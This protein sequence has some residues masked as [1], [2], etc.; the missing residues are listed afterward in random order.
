MSERRRV[1]LRRWRVPG[2]PWA[3]VLLLVL[4]L[5]VL[6]GGPLSERLQLADPDRTNVSDVRAVL[7]SLPQ[8]P[9]VIVGM[10]ADLGTYPEIRQAV[11]ALLAD[12]LAADGRI[13][14]V[15]FSPEG[16]AIADAEMGRLLSEGIAVDRLVDY[17]F[18]AGAEAGLV[19]AVTDLP[20]AE[21]SNALAADVRAL[22]GGIAA[23]DVAIVVGGV[24]FGPRSWVEQVATRLP[25]LPIVA[26]APTFAEP[27]L[28]PYLR[29]GQVKALLATVRDDA[30][31]VEDVSRR[32]G[33]GAEA[34]PAGPD[35][36]A[37]LIGMLVA[38]GAIAWSVT[39]GGAG[40][41]GVGRSLEEPS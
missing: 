27:E 12:L 32:I 4:G 18:V 16:R 36:T 2:M 25:S 40:N 7:G 8:R 1:G 13:A 10:D 23:F 38:I 35:A 19:L 9:L 34:V 6:A 24:D 30:A 28:A 21:D 39:R 26:V 15:S 14:T 5:A 41:G 22:G 11:R 17:G 31:Y 20:E 3:L 33:G 29:T 37:M